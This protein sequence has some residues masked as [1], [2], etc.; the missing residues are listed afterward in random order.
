MERTAEHIK[1]LGLA[2]LLAVLTHLLGV[3]CAMFN[4]PVLD[5]KKLVERICDILEEDEIVLLGRAL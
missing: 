2:F 1:G 5:V 3:S 4:T